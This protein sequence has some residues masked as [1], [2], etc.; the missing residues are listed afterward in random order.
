MTS[1]YPNT[2]LSWKEN[3]EGLRKNSWLYPRE[4][5]RIEGYIADTSLT[6]ATYRKLYQ[7]FQSRIN[8][9]LGYWEGSL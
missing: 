8:R 9:R 1:I 3:L 6:E 7:D 4:Q 5:K 2:S